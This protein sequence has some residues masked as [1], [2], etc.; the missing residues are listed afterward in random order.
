MGAHTNDGDAFITATAV[1]RIDCSKCGVVLTT[2]YP[3]NDRETEDLI[4]EH[5]RKHGGLRR[6][7]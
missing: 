1:T 7:Y 6:G 5:A 3:T 4:R 2:K